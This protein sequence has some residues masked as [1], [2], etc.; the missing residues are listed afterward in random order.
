MTLNRSVTCISN[1]K[2]YIIPNV[3]HMYSIVNITRNIFYFWEGT[4][5]KKEVY[6]KILNYYWPLMSIT[7]ADWSIQQEVYKF[8]R[9]LEM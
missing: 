4:L 7:K 1:P 2:L 3:L 5:I 8:L 6:H 9:K